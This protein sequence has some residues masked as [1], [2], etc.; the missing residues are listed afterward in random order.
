MNQEIGRDVIALNTITIDFICDHM[1]DFMTFVSCY[2]DEIARLDET[3]P[4]GETTILNFVSF[5]QSKPIINTF[6]YVFGSGIESLKEQFIRQY[7][8][9]L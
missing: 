2:K 3:Y 8:E 9:V 5:A 4:A 1:G 6:T 7:P